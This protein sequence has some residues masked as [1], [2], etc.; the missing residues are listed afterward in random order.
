MTFG[1]FLQEKFSSLPPFRKPKY[2]KV[3]E[4]KHKEQAEVT[5]P[6]PCPSCLMLGLQRRKIYFIFYRSLLC[7]QAANS[8]AEAEASAK[9]AEIAT[10]HEKEAA[11]RKTVGDYIAKNGNEALLKATSLMTTLPFC[12]LMQP[13]LSSDCNHTVMIAVSHTILTILN[14]NDLRE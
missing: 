3:A 12:F 6:A 14:C 10:K 11:R 7:T 9:Q 1:G 4:A 13:V 8:A 2:R 5:D